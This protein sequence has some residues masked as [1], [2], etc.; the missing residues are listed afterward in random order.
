MK[1]S[2]HQ[3]EVRPLWQ[4]LVWLVA[5]WCISVLALGGMAYLLRLF[6]RAAGLGV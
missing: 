1:P 4:R 3:P 5:L 6:M 2:E